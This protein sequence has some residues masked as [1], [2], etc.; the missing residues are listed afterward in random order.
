MG[1]EKFQKIELI[2]VL[3]SN[4]QV[5]TAPPQLASQILEKM[6]RLSAEFG[7]SVE[8]EGGR[9]YVKIKQG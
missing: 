6:Q 2:P 5:N 8:V 7:T 3:I 4:M 1:D 9:G